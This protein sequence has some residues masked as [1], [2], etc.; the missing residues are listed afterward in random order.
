MNLVRIINHEVT[1]NQRFGSYAKIGRRAG[2]YAALILVLAFGAMFVSCELDGSNDDN[3]QS[4]DDYTASVMPEML[5]G[6]W[7][8]DWGGG[9]IERYIINAETFISENSYAGTIVGHRSKENAGYITIQLTENSSYVDPEDKF[10]VIHYKDLTSSTL[11]IA[12]A[13]HADDPAFEYGVG[14][15][16]KETQA[17]AES[18]MTVSAGYFGM[19]SSLNRESDDVPSVIILE[20]LK[21]TWESIWGEE[22]IINATTF[23]SGYGGSVSYT[24]TIIAHN[25]DGADAGYITIQYTENSTFTD[26]EGKFYVIHYK[27]LTSSTFSVSGASNSEDPDFDFQSETAT[28]GK[29]TQAE[30]E[31]TMTVA[32]GYFGFYSDCYKFNGT[33]FKNALEGD[34]IDYDM[35]MIFVSIT[36][37]RI[38]VSMDISMNATPS[39]VTIFIGEIVKAAEAEEEDT[40]YIVFRYALIGN[41]M[42]NADIINTYTVLY[43]ENHDGDEVKL[44]IGGSENMYTFS[45]GEAS[46]AAAESKYI[47]GTYDFSDDL[48]DFEK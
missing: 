12:G 25:A 24:G 21:G 16:G 15:G 26:S 43:W 8:Y 40:G 42:A 48:M 30:A 4:N 39:I 46:I 11:S 18:A 10:Y 1:S 20:N 6:T 19:Y 28:G 29:A 14:S 13:Y 7:S 27:N 34:W 9:Y 33:Q 41:D 44:A 31:S 36:D 37:K 32:G 22:Y 17:E 35:E 5:K 23:T 3:H 47:N 38:K 45:A 2:F